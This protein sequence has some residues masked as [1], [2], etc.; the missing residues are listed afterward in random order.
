MTE[1]PNLE[2]NGLVIDDYGTEIQ[3]IP[4]D[5]L[6]PAQLLFTYAAFTNGKELTC[7]QL[8]ELSEKY[9]NILYLLI[10]DDLPDNSPHHLA[11]QS[12]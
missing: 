10:K 11:Y 2:L 1:Y 7:G 4:E 9:R 8:T 5:Q 6:D 3:G 12:C